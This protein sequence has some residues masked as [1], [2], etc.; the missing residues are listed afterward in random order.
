M[1][2]Q[3]R[4]MTGAPFIGQNRV[5]EATLSRLAV[6]ASTTSGNIR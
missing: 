3:S 6:L 5:A 4:T 2:L 1:L